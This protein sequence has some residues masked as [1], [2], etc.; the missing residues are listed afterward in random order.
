MN[1][2][3]STPV[4]GFAAY[5]GTGKTTLLV[6]LLPL[7]TRQNIRVA[8]IKHA[9]H[10]FEIDHEG[11]DSYK[12]RKAGAQQLLIGSEKRWALLVENHQQKKYKLSDFIAQLDH[13][14]IDLV[15]VEGFKPVQIPKIE[16]VRPALGNPLFYPEDNSVIAIATDADLPEKTELPVLDINNPEQIAD[17]I[18]NNFLPENNL[19]ANTGT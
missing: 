13:D 10:T 6:K 7:L 14:T 3:Q 2:N 15:L 9:H 17:F 11:K 1:N 5:S 12:L 16:L 8:M 19:S 4:L 18:I